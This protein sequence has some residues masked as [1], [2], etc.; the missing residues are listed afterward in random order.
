M[1]RHRNIKPQDEGGLLAPV[2][3][4]LGLAGKLAWVRLILDYFRGANA[5]PD[6]F[7]SPLD[8]D[9]DVRCSMFDWYCA[10][11]GSDSQGSR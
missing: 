1:M 11:E 2:V 5:R 7:P 10:F 4:R 8:L 6:S 3:S 9:T